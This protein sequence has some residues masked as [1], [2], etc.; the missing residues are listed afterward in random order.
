MT[1]RSRRV[2][3][4]TIFAQKLLRFST[5]FLDVL[6]PRNCIVFG[7][8]LNGNRA[9]LLS[10][11]GILRLTF[12]HKENACEHCGI[13]ISEDEGMI[14]K[15]CIER[16]D[17]SEL[18]FEHARSAVI[19]DEFSRPI[20]HTLKY[21]FTPKVA[22]DIARAATYSR[23]FY[24]HLGN[25][26]LVPVP[27]HKSRLRMRG[28]NQSLFLAREFAKFARGAVVEEVLSRTRQTQ[29]QTQLKAEIRRKNVRGAF[30]VAKGAKINPLARYVLID[31]VFTTGSTLSECARALR[32]AGAVSI[33][34]AT[35]A[36]AIPGSR[37]LP[38]S[39][40]LSHAI[41]GTSDR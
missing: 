8:P 29:T 34:A 10:H 30:R 39:T 14:C 1:S 33:D 24:E 9:E 12:I 6:I 38:T 32:K 15:E 40:D 22:R 37:N 31:D 3:K 27:L 18:Q 19:F 35:F 21:N 36:H 11:E 5:A 25:A 4:I 20:I 13:L 2:R 26:I 41:A 16:R 7:T 28:Y 17:D 23:G